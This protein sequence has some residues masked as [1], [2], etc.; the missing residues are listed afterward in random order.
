MR[1]SI[2][3][4]RVSN[5]WWTKTCKRIH[6]IYDCSMPRDTRNMLNYISF[7]RVCVWPVQGAKNIWCIIAL[8][9]AKRVWYWSLTV[10][11]LPYCMRLLLVCTLGVYNITR[12]KHKRSIITHSTL[13]AW[14]CC[15][16]VCQF[17]QLFQMCLVCVCVCASSLLYCLCVSSR[18]IL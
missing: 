5:N 12:E 18:S 2:A 15:Q 11:T 17:V 1:W 10:S 13:C 7:K 9:N 16:C 3:A 4:R 14:D 8:F 6:T